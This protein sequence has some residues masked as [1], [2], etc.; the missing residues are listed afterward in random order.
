MVSTGDRGSA[1]LAEE[2][3]ANWT[4]PR[5]SPAFCDAT[6]PL[7][8][9]GGRPPSARHLWSLR[10]ERT[11]VHPDRTLRASTPGAL[12]ADFDHDFRADRARLGRFSDRTLARAAADAPVAGGHLA[13]PRRSRRAQRPQTQR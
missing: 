9:T 1:A 13:R 7:R 3:S 10:A 5:W 12:A 6:A 4:T 2:W 11:G 8:S